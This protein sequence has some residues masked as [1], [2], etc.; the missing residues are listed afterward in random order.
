M[1]EKY[2]GVIRRV[3]ILL[4]ILTFVL[5]FMPHGDLFPKVGI[6]H[7]KVTY[8]RVA[9]IEEMKKA[10]SGM[11]NDMVADLT[12]QFQ[13]QGSEDPAKAAKDYVNGYYE[14]IKNKATTLF[15]E[16]SANWN[17]AAGKE[18]V[19]LMLADA[20]VME[21]QQY[22]GQK[23]VKKLVNSSVV[24]VK[25]KK[26][27]NMGETMKAYRYMGTF[28]NKQLSK[29][30]VT[31]GVNDYYTSLVMMSLA[32]FVFMFCILKYD[33][34]SKASLGLGLLVSSGVGMWANFCNES[35]LKAGVGEWVPTLSAKGAAHKVSQTWP[36]IGYVA[37]ALLVIYSVV[38]IVVDLKSRKK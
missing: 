23:G 18:L 3:G 33:K 30:V 17:K 22:I 4:A 26:Y 7:V 11:Y 34:N 29:Q 36:I 28:F 9:S 20:Q 1:K 31:T 16:R 25:Q 5:C 32:F 6:T 27:H 8:Y 15:N 10:D 37:F 24:M 12:K 14:T 13:A 2:F 38:V 21:G 35:K 19:S